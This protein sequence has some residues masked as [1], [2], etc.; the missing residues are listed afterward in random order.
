MNTTLTPM[1]M[2]VIKLVAPIIVALTCIFILALYR[3]DNQEADIQKIVNVLILQLVSC[4]VS[5]LCSIFFWG[6]TSFFV[7]IQWLF[8]PSILYSQILTYRYIFIHT[9]TKRGEQ[10]SLWHYLWPLIPGM[11]F[12]ISIFIYP[13]SLREYIVSVRPSI[14]EAP[15]FYNFMIQ[16]VSILFLLT[17]IIYSA[18]SICR[19]SRYRKAVVNFSADES[20]TSLLW[21]KWLVYITLSSIPLGIITLIFGTGIA[22]TLF[23]AILGVAAVILKGVIPIHNIMNREYVLMYTI[24]EL[25]APEEDD[26]IDKKSSIIKVETFERYIRTKKPYLNPDL[27][28]TDLLEPLG[29]NRTYLSSFINSQYGMNFSRYINHLRLK[30]L[31]HRR[32]LPKNAAI[33]GIEL[34]EQ[35]GFR[36]YRNYLNFKHKEDKQSVISMK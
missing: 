26:S 32:S 31:E 9:V 16:T 17:N 11:L 27:R 30:E 6:A 33:E 5:W 21:L 1:I 3:K 19:I 10:F 25:E 36:T 8:V 7:Y 12:F 20:R 13:Q 18:F 23:L 15:Q 22:I 2:M 29:T 34:V 24:A 14:K 28:I 35:V 4:V